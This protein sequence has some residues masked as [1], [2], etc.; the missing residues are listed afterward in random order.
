[1]ELH[2]VTERYREDGEIFTELMIELKS[3]SDNYFIF[4][5]TTQ[6]PRLNAILPSFSRGVVTTDRHHSQYCQLIDGG[7]LQRA[8]KI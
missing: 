6:D 3:S 8:N 5:S 4:F 2:A 1:M 7:A